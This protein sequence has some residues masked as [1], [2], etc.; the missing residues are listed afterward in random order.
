MLKIF[1]TILILQLNLAFASENKSQDKFIDGKI[2]DS[3]KGIKIPKSLMNEIHD[4]YYQQMLSYDPVR[5]EASTKQEVVKQLKRKFLE[6]KA[7]L[8]DDVQ[9]Q[10][11]SS[12]RLVMPRGGGVVDLKQVLPQIEKLWFRLKIEL[13]LKDTDEKIISSKHFKVFFVSNQKKRN[14]DYKEYGMGCNKYVDITS[15][16]KQIIANKGMV[17]PFADQKY[18]SVAGGAF[19]FAYTQAENLYLGSLGVYDSRYADLQCDLLKF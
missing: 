19:I 15:Y 14:V 10:L 6:V 17:L 8:F 9:G 7:Y 16:F 1:L 12:T 4:L 11:I 13:S 18:I 3:E 5:T 2:I